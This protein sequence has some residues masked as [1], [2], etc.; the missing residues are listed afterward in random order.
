MVRK[1]KI[2]ELFNSK[3]SNPIAEVLAKHGFKYLKSKK[4][5]IRHGKDFNQL[6]ILNSGSAYLS[7]NE[8]TEQIFLI[9]NISSQIEI[10]EY[11]KWCMEEIGERHSFSF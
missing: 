3:V 2:E 4:H 9:F 8:D 1:T 6:I 11:E 7:Y 10:P 5:F